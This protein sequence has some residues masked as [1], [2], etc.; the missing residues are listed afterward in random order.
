[1]RALGSVRTMSAIT[2]YNDARSGA[3]RA[4]LLAVGAVIGSAGL[5]CGVLAGLGWFVRR[6]RIRSWHVLFFAVFLASLVPF[7]S[8]IEPGASEVFFLEFGLVAVGIVSAE[9]I[10]RLLARRD[11]A[12]GLGAYAVVW[13]GVLLVAAFLPLHGWRL[14]GRDQTLLRYGLFTAVVL[15][16]ALLAL[17]TAGARRN[18]AVRALVVTILAAAALNVPLDLTVPHGYQRAGSGLTPGLLHGLDWVRTH[19]PATAVLAANNYWADS[20]TRLPDD[21]Y[22]SAFSERRV[23]LEGWVT[24]LAWWRMDPAA[25]ARGE[26]A[27]PERLSLNEAVFQRAD[28]HALATLV[29]RYG[30]RY[31]VVDH[32]HR[33]ASPRVARLGRRVFDNRDV[34]VYAVGSAA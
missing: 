20:R 17:A 5:L 12:V 33:S 1:F 7:Y 25:A 32:V 22:Y 15:A 8:L 10:A 2:F 14:A 26:A 23:F 34:T 27:Y 4:L 19:T 24:S 16:L 11:H 13:T 29:N 21:F 28:R 6:D 31:L 9:G 3:P 18:L 30:V